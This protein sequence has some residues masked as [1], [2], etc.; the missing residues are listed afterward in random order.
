MRLLQLER[1]HLVRVAGRTVVTQP[2]E[3][4]LHVTDAL[5]DSFSQFWEADRPAQRR[6]I[7]RLRKAAGTA[8]PRAA[9]LVEAARIAHGLAGVALMYGFREAGVLAMEIEAAFQRG[10]VGA[11]LELLVDQLEGALAAPYRSRSTRR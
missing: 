8:R 1:T 11:Q 3:E 5:D 2:G 9:S 10:A 4:D 7:A 6:R